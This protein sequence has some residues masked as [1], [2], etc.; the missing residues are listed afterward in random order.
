MPA[1]ASFEDDRMFSPR[2]LPRTGNTARAVVLAFLLAVATPLSAHA[3]GIFPQVT[4]ENLEQRNY[5]LPEDFEGKFNILV[6]AYKREQ[7][8]LVDSWFPAF[9]R[10]EQNDRSVRFYE[11]PVIA[12]LTG[13]FMRWMIDRGMRRGIPSKD[14]RARVITLYVDKDAFKTALHL[15]ASEDTIY[16]LLVDRRGRVLWRGEGAYSEVT[17]A[18]LQRAIAQNR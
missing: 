15:P 8:E 12:R 9:R 16:I 11:L 2:P 5:R 10:I 4:A 17:A 3:A 14:K 18:S 7:Q 6:I 1:I 13:F